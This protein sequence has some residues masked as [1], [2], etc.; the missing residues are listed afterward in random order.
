MWFRKCVDWA[1]S[2]LKKL[3]I[4]DKEFDKEFNSSSFL[5]QQTI[6]EY[7]LKTDLNFQCNAVQCKQHF[8]KDSKVCSLS[9]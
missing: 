4:K 8:I 6:Y 5:K 1:V 2:S 9:W 7:K 3:L